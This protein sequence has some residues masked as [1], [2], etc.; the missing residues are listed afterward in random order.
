[1]RTTLSRKYS[2]SPHKKQSSQPRLKQTQ[3]FVGRIYCT[4]YSVQVPQNYRWQNGKQCKRKT[5]TVQSSLARRMRHGCTALLHRVAAK[6]LI[7]NFAKFYENFAKH[8]VKNFSKILRNYNNKNFAAALLLHN[9]PSATHLPLPSARR[10]FNVARQC[11]FE[12]KTNTE[13]YFSILSS[14][15]LWVKHSG[16]HI[17]C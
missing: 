11:Y 2:E 4:L 3:W 16:E 8:Q 6:F 17:M 13:T 7:L 14:I 9:L 10:F 1:M 5:N 12:M 15:I